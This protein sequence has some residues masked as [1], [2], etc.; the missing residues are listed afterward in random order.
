MPE[1]R[2]E[3]YAQALA[4]VSPD[5][6]VP[7]RFVATFTWIYAQFGATF[8]G[9]R[10]TVYLLE[11]QTQVRCAVYAYAQP[12]ACRGYG[13]LADDLSR[14]RARRWR[15]GRRWQASRNSGIRRQQPR[16]ERQAV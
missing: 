10:R 14:S 16:P 8:R 9:P 3:F 12:V 1:V 11:N 5:W 15:E 6:V 2:P 4:M 13:A 7:V